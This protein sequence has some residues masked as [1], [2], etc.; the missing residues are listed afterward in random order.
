MPS[1][2]AIF[3]GLRGYMALWVLLGHCAYVAKFWVP[4]I[5][6]PLL[7]VYVFMFISGFLM[8]YNYY[9]RED[10]EAWNRWSTFARFYTRRFF[11]ISP[12]YYLLFIG[13]FCVQVIFG[14]SL[15]PHGPGHT[16]PGSL[17]PIAD[18]FLHVT[19]LFGL[20][21][22]YAASNMLPDWSLSLE[23]QFY[24]VFPLL[25]L[26]LRR[27]GVAA[28]SLLALAA[29][30]IATKAFVWDGQPYPPSDHAMLFYPQP[31]LLMLQ[32]TPF[33]TGILLA[34]SILC[35]NAAEKVISLALC[36]IFAGYK[37]ETSYVLIIAFVAVALHADDESPFSKTF[38]RPWTA[39]LASRP[40][41]YLG[42]ISY[43]VYLIHALALFAF[44][45]LVPTTWFDPLPAYYRFGI[46]AGFVLLTTGIAAVICHRVVE[47]PFIQ[48]GHKIANRESLPIAVSSS[49][50]TKK[51]L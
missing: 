46:L 2:L 26:C 38:V 7:A 16:M 10:R 30:L 41:C 4:V 12:L 48:L 47:L 17:E 51:P 19:Y 45:Y 25:M 15:R 14:I 27:L 24:I 9:R 34:N 6:K 35:S 22:A 50:S 13:I 39:I 23:V 18:F 44:G 43:S 36:G 3:D 32:I 31:S 42:D 20:F 28:I 8:T 33:M 49:P 37:E 29:Y 21:P 5:D 1:K 11:R 40:S